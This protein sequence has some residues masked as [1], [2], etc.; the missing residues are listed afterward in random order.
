MAGKNLTS[1]T[2]AAVKPQPKRYWLWSKDLRG[3][4]L[5][6]QPSGAKSYYYVTRVS[7]T[8]K[9]QRI[10]DHGEIEFAAARTLRPS[11]PR[12]PSMLAPCR[13][14]TRPRPS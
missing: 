7:G 2:A 11:S 5:S 13:R 9:F 1:T 14:S 8:Q 6:V 3:F 4:G 12:S 10:A